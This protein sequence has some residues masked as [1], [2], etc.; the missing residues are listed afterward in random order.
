MSEDKSSSP[1]DVAVIGLGATGQAVF[2]ALHAVAAARIVAVSDRDAHRA[3]EMGRRA[4]AAW[5]TDNR[6]LLAEA[7]PQAVFVSVPPR[8]AVEVIGACAKRGIHVWKDIPLARSLD[9]GAAMVKRMEKASLVFSVG[10]R[11]RFEPGY[12]SCGEIKDLLGRIFLCRAHY[13]FNWGA[14]LGWRTDRATAGG[15]AQL[16]LAYHPIDLMTWTLGLPEEVFG[17]N[18]VAERMGADDDPHPQHDTDDT[19][20]AILR[21]KQGLM[22]TVV[23]TRRSGP[24]SEEFC[25][26]GSGGSLRA[27][28]EQYQLLGPEGN[29]VRSGPGGSYSPGVAIRRQVEAFVE[30]AST[31]ANLYPCSA[32]ENLLNL[33]VIEA[34]YLSDRTGHP[35]SPQRLLA[36]NKL[37]EADC[38]T[39]RQQPL[40]P[41]PAPSQSPSETAC[42]E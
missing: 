32:R 35:E 30:A 6:S 25:M 17:V 33:A 36:N 1:L 3:E 13:L 21:Y 15:G 9:E 14:P 27:G 28:C 29:L 19:A 40:W 31:R 4:G 23:T 37:S 16:E 18:A 10:T 7:R 38:L 11:W 2:E 26:H 24:V 41:G 8:Q 39:H 34:L 20:A 12:A 5:Y 22:A 42:D